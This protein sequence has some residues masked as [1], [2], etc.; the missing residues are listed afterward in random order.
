MTLQ[1][2]SLN[3]MEMASIE[4]CCDWF[5]KLPFP[6]NQYEVTHYFKLIHRVAIIFNDAMEQALE[7][8]KNQNSNAPVPDVITTRFTLS[9]KAMEIA[10][11]RLEV[12]KAIAEAIQKTTLLMQDNIKQV[13]DEVE[14]RKNRPA[15]T[16]MIPGTDN[17]FV[18]TK[19]KVK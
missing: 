1:Y 16:P 14:A 7:F 18:F 2:P 15:R 13:Q 10:G 6:S 12:A 4:Q 8:V 19:E 11:K 5:D 17:V 3:E 9:I